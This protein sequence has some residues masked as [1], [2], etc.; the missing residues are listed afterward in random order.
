MNVIN[1]IELQERTLE[2]G[3]AI[4][5]KVFQP[6]AVTKPVVGVNAG[7]YW[8][9]VPVGAAYDADPIAGISHDLFDH[10][11]TDDGSTGCEAAAVI[12][13]HTLLGVD[14]G[15]RVHNTLRWLVN[16]VEPVHGFNHL[17]YEPITEV[18][19]QIRDEVLFGVTGPNVS[20]DDRVRYAPWAVFGYE[21]GLVLYRDFDINKLQ[22][23]FGGVVDDHCPS[24][25]SS[26]VPDVGDELVV[27]F[28]PVARVGRIDCE[29]FNF[30]RT[31]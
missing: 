30:R 19:R 10:F 23:W 5:D 3:C 31:F 25:Y 11:Q 2:K 15:V 1:G 29:A 28:D 9:W 12:G 8:G 4:K 13:M 22:R 21:T 20:R 24:C 7:Q 26:N 16:E 14:P 17:E 27:N 6:R 18:G